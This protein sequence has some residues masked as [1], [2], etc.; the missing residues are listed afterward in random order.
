M[1][2]SQMIKRFIVKATG[3]EIKVIIIGKRANY[4]V[5][6]MIFS[7][8]VD[9]ETTILSIKSQK[10]SSENGDI[11]NITCE[12]SLSHDYTSKHYSPDGNNDY[13][14]SPAL[15]LTVHNGEIFV[16]RNLLD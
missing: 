5:D 7:K 2:P 14:Y 3:Q 15:L 6:K 16:N 12:Q 9:G 1:Q 8:S 10:L 4:E 11:L 13:K